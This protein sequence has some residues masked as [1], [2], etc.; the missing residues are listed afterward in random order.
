MFKPVEVKALPEYRLWLRYAD[1]AQGEVDLSDLAGKG[2]FRLWNEYSAFEGVHI[3][4][5][6]EIAWRDGIELCP[7][8]L[9][10]RLTGKTPEEVF[11]NLREISVN[12]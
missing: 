7:D 3:G 10:L 6:H 4:R 2:V 1:G 9:Y 11:P 12:A 8:A 5:H